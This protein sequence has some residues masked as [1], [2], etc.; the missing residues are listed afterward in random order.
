MREGV[1]AHE[2]QGLGGRMGVR[3]G[4]VNESNISNAANYTNKLSHSQVST[5]WTCNSAL[6]DGQC[7]AGCPR[8]VCTSMMVGCTPLHL[9]LVCMRFRAF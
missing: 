6:R 8:R 7:S 5:P 4:C 3:E 9:I 1:D 2:G